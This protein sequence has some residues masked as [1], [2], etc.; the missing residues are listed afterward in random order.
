MGR[1]GQ[2]NLSVETIH[3]FKGINVTALER[4]HW[5]IM[6]FQY[7]RTPPMDIFFTHI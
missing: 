2:L 1:V 7:N 5:F 4:M 6:V 3:S